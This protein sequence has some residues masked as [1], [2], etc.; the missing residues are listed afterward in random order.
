M[1][2]YDNYEDEDD[3][4]MRRLEG[5]DVEDEPDEQYLAEKRKHELDLD[6]PVKPAVKKAKAAKQSRALDDYAIDP[7]LADDDGD[8]MAGFIE[9]DMD[10]DDE[11]AINNF[12][13]AIEVPESAPKQPKV[14]RPKRVVKNPRPKL[15]SDTLKSARGLVA[16]RDAQK[17]LVLK[18][19][20]HELEDLNKIMFTLEHW[21]HRLHP[22]LNID[23]FYERC[24]KLG[25]QRLI[26]TY[27]RKM[28]LDMPLEIT[29]EMVESDKEDEEEPADPDG[30]ELDPPDPDAP[31]MTAEEAF[32]KLFDSNDQAN[33]A[34]ATNEATSNNTPAASVLTDE[35]RQLIAQKRLEAIA[36]RQRALAAQNETASQPEQ[37]PE[38]SANAGN[39]DDDGNLSEDEILRQLNA[40]D[41]DENA[42][43]DE[44]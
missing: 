1:S 39:E 33:T 20:G 21:A 28:R 13:E 36:R 17:S 40:P 42:S 12:D 22:H 11:N 30:M 23:D 14:I 32:D 3:E 31:H 16:L 24:A 10:E 43:G 26:S 29:G 44:V 35:Q 4:L 7:L 25:S 41:S 19:K 34:P 18:G 2:Y 38:T 27:M 5:R 9:N 37:A 6:A 15:N 8:D